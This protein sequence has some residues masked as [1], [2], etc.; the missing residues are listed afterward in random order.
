M[1]QRELG[2]LARAPH[3]EAMIEPQQMRDSVRGVLL[4]HHLF[5]QNAAP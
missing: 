1:W 4:R 5:V 3:A 2:E